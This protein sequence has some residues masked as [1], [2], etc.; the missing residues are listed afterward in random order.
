MQSAENKQDGVENSPADVKD[1]LEMLSQSA[2]ENDRDSVPHHMLHK[3]L[4]CA[5]HCA[6]CWL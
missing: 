3:H 1:T 5:S 4:L 2:D 6:R